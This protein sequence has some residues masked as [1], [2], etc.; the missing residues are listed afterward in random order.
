MKYLLKP[1]HCI[2]LTKSS[3]VKKVEKLLGSPKFPVYWNQID[4]KYGKYFYHW[5][6]Q[7]VSFILTI[8]FQVNVIF[9]STST[10]LPRKALEKAVLWMYTDF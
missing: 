8:Y 7:E 1:F 4:F 10:V 5:S 9:K 2:A 6:D 3:S